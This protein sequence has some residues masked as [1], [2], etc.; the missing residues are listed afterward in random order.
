MTEKWSTKEQHH[1]YHTHCKQTN[2]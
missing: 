2:T 1:Y